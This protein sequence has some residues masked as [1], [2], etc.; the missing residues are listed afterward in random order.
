MANNKILYA[1]GN[2]SG[3]GFRRGT[4]D[5]ESDFIGMKFDDSRHIENF[6]MNPT[7]KKNPDGRMT[8]RMTRK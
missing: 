1:N 2:N 6:T 8:M 7:I 4:E 3:G 5:T